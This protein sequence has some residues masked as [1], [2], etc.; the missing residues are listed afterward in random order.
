MR[1]LSQRSS[2]RAA[3]RLRAASGALA[4]V[5]VVGACARASGPVGDPAVLLDADSAFDAEVAVGGSAA[6][7]AWFAADGALIRP[8]AGEIRGLD[9]L[10]DAVRSL[11]EPGTAL[12]WSPT[13]ADIAA[14]GDLGWT[15][16]R[17]VAT[18]TAPD[19]TVTRGEGHYVSIWRRQP[20]GAWKVVMDLGNP[21]GP[22]PGP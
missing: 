1:L 13:R 14:S 11:D 2:R 9:A 16:G 4:S 8:G 17:Y 21:V 5:L 18:S 22:P 7:V 3:C 20:D 6:W 10:R 19:G 15:T 12:R